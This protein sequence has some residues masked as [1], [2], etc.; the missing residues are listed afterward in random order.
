MLH[1]P[2]LH[3]GLHFPVQ[4]CVIV[5]SI[6]TENMALVVVYIHLQSILFGLLPVCTTEHMMLIQSVVVRLSVPSADEAVFTIRLY[7]AFH[8]LTP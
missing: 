3:D 5:Y 7:D 4:L 8:S 6:F 2:F 1:S